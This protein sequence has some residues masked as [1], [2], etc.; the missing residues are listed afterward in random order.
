MWDGF[1]KIVKPFT[2]LE[3]YNYKFPYF[4][5]WNIL[6]FICISTN[7]DVGQSDFDKA[8]QLYKANKMDQASLKICLKSSPSI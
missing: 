7:Y 8:E 3:K 6:L 2:Y 4:E 1:L 5:E